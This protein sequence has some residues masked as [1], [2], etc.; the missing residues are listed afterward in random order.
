MADRE[1]EE[2]TTTGVQ[3]RRGVREKGGKWRGL[4]ERH[5]LSPV[6]SVRYSSYVTAACVEVRGLS[7][8][9]SC[10]ELRL[11]RLFCDEH[12]ARLSDG[13]AILDGY[14][15]MDERVIRALERMDPDQAQRIY[16]DIYEEAV[17]PV[18]TLILA[19]MWNETHKLYAV[20]REEFEVHILGSGVRAMG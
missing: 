14:R 10:Y 6:A 11:L 1:R 12:V 19:G 8:G 7:D 18:V 15:R 3:E 20:A 5:L 4:P 13:P 9:G 16:E 17:A 2:K